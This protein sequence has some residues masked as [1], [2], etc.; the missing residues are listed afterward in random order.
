MA[1]VVFVMTEFPSLKRSWAH[2]IGLADGRQ[3]RCKDVAA[4]GKKMAFAVYRGGGFSVEY[5]H[6]VEDAVRRRIAHKKKGFVR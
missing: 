6:Y 5:L 3:A 2:C 4:S 1:R